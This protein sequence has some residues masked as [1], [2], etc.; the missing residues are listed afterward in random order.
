VKYLNRS[1]IF[2]FTKPTEAHWFLP[3]TSF[4]LSSIAEERVNCCKG[5]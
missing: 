3:M 2:V 5:L 4:R 1:F